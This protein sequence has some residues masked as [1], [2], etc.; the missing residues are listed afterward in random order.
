[1]TT[2]MTLFRRRYWIPAGIADW[3]AALAGLLVAAGT[4]A[5][6]YY[7]TG[8]TACYAGQVCRPTPVA[9]PIPLWAFV[10][11]LGLVGL[12][13]GALLFRFR[14][15]ALLIGFGLAV[16]LFWFGSL[17]LGW[18]FFPAGLVSFIAG[19]WPH[20]PRRMVS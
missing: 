8:Y 2:Q 3:L 4:V 12:V 16:P 6:E 7:S 5:T 11:I 14:V 19:V 17:G 13:A 9:H 10:P 18:E 15:R 1:M 20:R